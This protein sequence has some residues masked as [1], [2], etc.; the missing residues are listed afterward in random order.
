MIVRVEDNGNRGR[1]AAPLASSSCACQRMTNAK[2][3]QLHGANKMMQSILIFAPDP[4]PPRPNQDAWRLDARSKEDIGLA[5]EIDPDGKAATLDSESLTGYG[6]SK[7]LRIG[8]Q[9]GWL[10]DRSIPSFC[11]V[12]GSSCLVSFAVLEPRGCWTRVFRRWFGQRRIL[13]M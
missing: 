1:T 13:L 2:A 7:P 11:P 6:V 4:H 8:A 5:V 3:K 9:V 12:F 10:I